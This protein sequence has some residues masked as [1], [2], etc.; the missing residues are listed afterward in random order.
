M[1]VSG[2]DAIVAAEAA[3]AIF[4]IYEYVR[5]ECKHKVAAVQ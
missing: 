3:R 4:G 5:Q 1:E 2:C